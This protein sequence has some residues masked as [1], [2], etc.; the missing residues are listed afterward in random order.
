MMAAIAASRAGARVQLWEK[1]PALG[2]KL[3]A[4]GNGRCNFSN[5]DL[6]L[7]H[8]HAPDPDFA[9]AVL[10]QFDGPR[11]LEFLRAIGV[12]A[13]CDEGGRYFPASSEASSVLLCLTEEMARCGVRV[14]LRSE[15]VGIERAG[16]GFGIRRRGGADEVG[17]VI[18]ACGG[19]ASPQLGSNGSG[20]ELA[21]QLGHTI[22]ALRPALVPIELVGPW[23]HKLQGIRWDMTLTISRAGRPAEEIT[24]EGLFAK[25]GL[26]GPIALRASRRLGEGGYQLELNFLPARSPDEVSTI[27]KERAEALP[28]RPS[29]D[30]LTGLLPTKLGRMIV[31]QTGVPTDLPCGK[32]SAKQ[33]ARLARNLTHWPMQMRGLRPFREAQVTVGGVEI[34]EVDP[35]TMES[36]RVAGL[37]FCG[38]VVDVDGDSG[39]YNL[40]WAWSSGHV[41]G[42]SA[43]SYAM[44]KPARRLP[45]S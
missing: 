7:E 6:S 18:I 26:S 36:R 11:T 38:E 20:C 43:A 33:I 30:F 2:R 12:E 44:G 1:N 39:G 42:R 14:N 22:T 9:R 31:E 37:F 32:L 34:S 17:A 23:F 21:R 8:F 10:Q 35:T 41:A 4:T 13:H 16:N 40:Q 45:S 24:D 25:Y 5:R 28:T 27:L 29:H 15:I 19:R 3:L